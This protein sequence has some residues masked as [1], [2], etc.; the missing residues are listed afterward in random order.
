MIA[1]SQGECQK[2]NARIFRANLLR[3][4]CNVECVED[5]TNHQGVDSRSLDGPWAQSTLYKSFESDQ[6]TMGL[7]VAILA[8]ASS[9]IS[10]V[11]S[12][13]K[14][15]LVKPCSFRVSFINCGTLRAAIQSPLCVPL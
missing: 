9:I 2:I 5:A 15:S 11:N 12:T 4:T 7:P 3:Q 8:C 6:K 10:F 13:M 14:A 1:V